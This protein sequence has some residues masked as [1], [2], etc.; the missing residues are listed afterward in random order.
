MSI[1]V[2]DKGLAKV[3]E[4]AIKSFA[5]ERC[6]TQLH[7]LRLCVALHASLTP[8]TKHEM[9]YTSSVAFLDKS[10][11]LHVKDLLRLQQPNEKML[12]TVRRA[13][14]LL[15]LA[16]LDREEYP[17]FID[18]PFEL[19]SLEQSL[20][21][22]YWLTKLL[23][24]MNKEQRCLFMVNDSSGREFNTNEEL[25]IFVF[26]YLELSPKGLKNALG[27][28]KNAI[29]GVF[30]QATYDV[31]VQRVF[32]SEQYVMEAEERPLPPPPPR[33]LFTAEVLD[34]HK[35]FLQTWFVRKLTKKTLKTLEDILSPHL[36]AARL[37]D[38]DFDGLG[39]YIQWIS[40]GTH[41]LQPSRPEYK[42][43]NAIFFE[44]FGEA[45]REELLD[46]LVK[47]EELSE[48]LAVQLSRP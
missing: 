11:L 8:P 45:L 13:F 20:K 17:L 18:Q 47:E 33:P 39:P 25:L 29:V 30:E 9:I 32:G 21:L 48:D 27:Y 15:D 16:I 10:F 35:K 3:A 2:E 22:R 24:T 34:K 14:S 12:D 7:R 40:S 5:E 38:R 28:W 31:L 36:K 4:H 6:N 19:E 42:K 44:C 41:M 43:F 46:Y 1:G 23:L 26:E 37:L